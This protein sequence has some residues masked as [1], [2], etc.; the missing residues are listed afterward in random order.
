MNKHL[1]LPV[2]V[3]FCFNTA[4]AQ[5]KK[6]HAANDKEQL[7][8]KRKASLQENAS[9]IIIL[10]SAEDSTKKSIPIDLNVKLK[11]DTEG[12][13]DKHPF[14][15]YFILIAAGLAAVASLAS[16]IITARLNLKSKDK[17]YLNDYHKK[18]IDKRIKAIEAVESLMALF[19]TSYTHQV[20]GEKKLYN[21]F[22]V[23]ELES[24][25]LSNIVDKMG[26]FGMWYSI[27]TIRSLEG[28]CEMIFPIV[29]RARTLEGEELVMYAIKQKEKIKHKIE[30]IEG[31]LGED[32]DKL[33]DVKGFFKAKFKNKHPSTEKVL[34]S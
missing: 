11:Q 6:L 15:V 5:S 18:V 25:K 17:E 13:V 10:K 28:F 27:N 7:V 20:N 9:S 4:Q 30:I 31:C 33:Y 24:E 16:S 19:S 14:A 8:S 23:D 32:M 12:V 26:E 3:A 1:L 34:Q 21:C 29:R 22:F 2:L